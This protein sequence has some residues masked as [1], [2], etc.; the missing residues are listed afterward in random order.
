MA[1]RR[2]QSCR[3]R[4]QAVGARSGTPRFSG[5]HRLIR[6]GISH[7]VDEQ[8][9]SERRCEYTEARPLQQHIRSDPENSN[10]R[11]RNSTQREAIRPNCSSFAAP[12]HRFRHGLPIRQRYS[13]TWC[14]NITTCTALSYT[15]MSALNTVCQSIRP[16]GHLQ[17]A[18]PEQGGI[19]K[20]V[21]RIRFP[22]NIYVIRCHLTVL[23]CNA[24]FATESPVPAPCPLSSALHR[25]C[26]S[27][28]SLLFSIFGCSR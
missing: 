16:P 10:S 25:H 9:T 12:V 28:T 24:T 11:V 17:A 8:T 7:S 14:D 13:A 26:S 6:L 19:V 18:R 23:V 21:I 20:V 1:E 4:C 2:C 22:G 27:L 5:N 15:D 3:V